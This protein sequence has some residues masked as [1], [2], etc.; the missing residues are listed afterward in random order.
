MLAVANPKVTFAQLRAV[1]SGNEVG[2]RNLKREGYGITRI[3]K[4]ASTFRFECWPWQTDPTGPNAAQYAG[5]PY[6]L[7]FASV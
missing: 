1:K 7:P 2:D 4:G 6:N 5:W 3:D